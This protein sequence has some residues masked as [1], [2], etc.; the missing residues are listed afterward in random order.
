[1]S[2]WKIKTKLYKYAR[3]HFIFR[4]ILKKEN[5]NLRLLLAKIPENR[6][7]ILDMGCGDGN[8]LYLLK[9]SFPNSRLMGMDFTI[10]MLKN[11]NEENNIPLIQADVSALPYKKES[12]DLCSAIGLIEYIKNENLF[13]ENLYDVLKTNGYVVISFAPKNLFTYLRFI[14]GIK[15]YAKN[16]NNYRQQII[17]KGFTIISVE[18]SLMQI[19]YLIKKNG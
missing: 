17:D 6:N 2:L 18:K 5:K 7:I 14:H 12:L 1:M 19:Q 13:F 10:N 4:L 3:Y 15:I 8:V 11:I 16:E 9:E